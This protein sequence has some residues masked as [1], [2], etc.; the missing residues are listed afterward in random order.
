MLDKNSFSGRKDIVFIKQIKLNKNM[1]QQE[2]SKEKLNKARD[3]IFNY[4]ERVTFGLIN[5]SKSKINLLRD[6]RWIETDL[7]TSHPYYEY[8]NYMK[9]GRKHMLFDVNLKHFMLNEF[10]QNNSKKALSAYNRIMEHFN[11]FMYSF[12]TIIESILLKMLDQ[13]DID[14]SNNDIFKSFGEEKHINIIC[15]KFKYVVNCEILGYNF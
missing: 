15:E 7:L 10:D 1:K 6:R 5:I 9:Y 11:I 8:S 12:I 2:V 13:K 4:F 14:V 3:L